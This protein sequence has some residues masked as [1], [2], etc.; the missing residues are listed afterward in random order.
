MT[1]VVYGASLLGFGGFAVRISTVAIPWAVLPPEVDSGIAFTWEG[2][3]VL[4]PSETLI[5]SSSDTDWS[6][7]ATGYVFQSA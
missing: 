5:F 4:Y 7:T 2:R 1:A 6:F 3:T